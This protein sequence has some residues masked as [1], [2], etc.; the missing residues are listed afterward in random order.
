MF[1]AQMYP[2]LGTKYQ[3]QM[4]LLM[5]EASKVSGPLMQDIHPSLAPVYADFRQAQ[6]R[7]QGRGW[8]VAARVGEG[9]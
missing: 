6:V 4:H 5:L 9:V 7:G 2:N 3:E 8:P 1:T